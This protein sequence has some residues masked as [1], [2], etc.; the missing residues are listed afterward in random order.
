MYL[1]M[2][3]ADNTYEKNLLEQKRLEVE[4][5]KESMVVDVS[6]MSED[7]DDLNI[8]LNN[9]CMLGV[10]IVRIWINDTYSTQNEILQPMSDSSIIQTVT[11]MVNT[12]YR[13]MVATER[14][15]VFAAE[16][17]LYYGENGWEMVLEPP[18]GIAET[19]VVKLEWFY[20]K[21]TSYEDPIRTEASI[22]PS[23]S[24]Y[25]ALY[26]KISNN[27]IYPI[28]IEDETFVTWIVPHI[29]VMMSIVDRV[30]Y[31]IKTIKPYSGLLV[32]QPGQSVELVFAAQE[33]SGNS[34]RWGSSIPSYLL[35]GNPARTAFLQV[36]LFYKLL[37]QLYCQTLTAQGVYLE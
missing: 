13:I 25:L 36:T 27:W 12:S 9:N 29:E 22:I 34:W 32:I 17:S 10:K 7:S 4:R 15:N 20:F 5:S 24:T 30:N 14:G 16:K 37:G 6:P 31:P 21:Y 11:P 3:Q 1:V 26:F 23:S 35:Q 33:K 28:M 8:T 19:G 18:P 2:R